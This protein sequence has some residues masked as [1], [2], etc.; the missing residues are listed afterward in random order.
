MFITAVDIN[1]LS[2]AVDGNY[3]LHYEWKILAKI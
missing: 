1:G 2:A 3:I